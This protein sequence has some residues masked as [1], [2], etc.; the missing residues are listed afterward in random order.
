MNL[1][2][3]EA[4]AHCSLSDQLFLNFLLNGPLG[5]EMG[6]RGMTLRTNLHEMKKIIKRQLAIVSYTFYNCLYLG[7]QINVRAKI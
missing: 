5:G 4:L 2:K 7:I 3:S 1:E 6:Y